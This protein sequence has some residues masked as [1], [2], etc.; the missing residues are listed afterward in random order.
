MDKAYEWIKLA[1][2]QTT[3]SSGWYVRK[4]LIEAKLGKYKDAI[5]TANK[6]KELALAKAGNDDLRAVLNDKSIEEWSK[7][8]K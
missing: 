4:A 7:L 5:A 1:L 6:S 2:G 3:K 8:K